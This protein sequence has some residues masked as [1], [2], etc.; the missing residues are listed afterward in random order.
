MQGI[1]EIGHLS[2]FFV[3]LQK[4]ILLHY[5]IIKGYLDFGIGICGKTNSWKKDSETQL[6]IFPI[7]TAQNWQKMKKNIPDMPL[8]LN[9]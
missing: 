3:Q 6:Y 7:L 9:L 4:C 8:P 5:A 2:L 1:K